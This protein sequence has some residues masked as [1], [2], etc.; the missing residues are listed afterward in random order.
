MRTKPSPLLP[1]FRS[2]MQTEILSALFL[3]PGREW[4]MHELSRHTGHAYA[5]VHR[6]ATRLVDAGLLVERRVGQARML[7]PNE[8]APAFRPL[9]DLLVVCFGPVPLLAE[10]LSHVP[11]IEAV[12]IYGSYAA[13]LKGVP[14]EPPEDVDLLVVGSPDP[15]EVY[16]A[17]RDVS[18]QVNRTVNPTI[19]DWQEWEQD[20]GFL[21]EVRANPVL[22]VLGD[23]SRADVRS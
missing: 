15:L 7:R 3:D 4:N 21:R 22:P 11:G 9:R 20:S 17:A 5:G 23:L 12:A 13:R 6:E 2:T 14:G 1:I 16:A 10:R 18:A 19:M 8:Q